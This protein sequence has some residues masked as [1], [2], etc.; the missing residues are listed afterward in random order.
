MTILNLAVTTGDTETYAT[1]SSIETALN[2]K[3]LFKSLA[4]GSRT[5]PTTVVLQ[6]TPVAA[7]GT[8]TSASGNG[9][10]NCVISGVTIAITYA[11]SDAH[12]A[13]LMKAAINASVDAHIAGV[14]VA[15]RVDPTDGI[16]TI[17]A[18]QKGLTG[19]AITSTASGT[20]ATAEQARLSGGT[21]GVATSYSF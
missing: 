15:T 18:V 5:Q 4:A 12:A 6:T 3:Q 8:W 7:S 9:T 2:L 14:V 21:V 19:N 11:T 10:M 20:G 16:V 1:A 13:D 17:T